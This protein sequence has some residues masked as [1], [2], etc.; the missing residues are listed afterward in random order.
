MARSEDQSH[1]T[2][3]KINQVTTE[4][5]LTFFFYLTTSTQ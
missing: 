4:Y 5:T 3:K 1:E 2:T